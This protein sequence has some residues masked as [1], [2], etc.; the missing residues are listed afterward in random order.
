MIAGYDPAR[1][2]DLGR[3][4]HTAVTGL[5]LITTTDPAADV[6]MHAIAMMRTVLT[7]G[8]I[9]AVDSI[10]RT[11]PLVARGIAN[12][13]GA[14]LFDRLRNSWRFV[15]VGDV[16]LL[17]LLHIAF[18]DQVEG[19]G[20]PDPDDPFWTDEFPELVT[21]Y[22][23]RARRD[24]SFAQLM[25]D[26]AG[27]NPL[28]GYV[29]A[30]GSFGDAVFVG[31]TAAIVVAEPLGTIP[32]TYRDEVVETLLQQAMATPRLAVM[33]AAE[34]GVLGT[35]FA[36]NERFD[37]VY[38]LP[39]AIVVD[40]VSVAMGYPLSEPSLMA[41]GQ[42]VLGRITE[43]A[44]EPYGR[45]FPEWVAPTIATG[46]TGY[47]P[48][49]LGS[50]ETLGSDVFFKN[51]NDR[52]TVPL[53]SPDEIV[54]LFGSLLR[55]PDARLVLLAAIPILA[56]ADPR[57][58]YD[59]ED[60]ADYVNLLIQAS[61][62]EQIQDEIRAAQQRGHWNI[63]IDVVSFAIETGIEVAGVPGDGAKIAV[64]IGAKGA[65]WLVSRIEAGDL[66]LDDVRGTAYLLLTLGLA[67]RFVTDRRTAGDD[68]S[69]L[70]EAEDTVD[71]IDDLLES[72]ASTETVE[73]R[74]RDLRD[75][76]DDIGGPDALSTLDD[77]RIEPT[78]F[79]AQRDTTAD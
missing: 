35:L 69:R 21:E 68:D 46:L 73:A 1:V 20:L 28:I 9:T 66:G 25:I 33:V 3:R 43:L 57:G 65:H 47:L 19:T 14:S 4:T 24:P 38:D 55:D 64:G 74:I 13:S 5:D 15:G 10:A 61:D 70:D 77:A 17:S 41:D 78:P 11:D 67:S 50:I 45:G 72:G 36:W 56:T 48:S 51:A 18:T 7:G 62:N 23:G 40:F 26:E 54:E 53:G 63:V 79:D 8:I 52:R 44:D 59:D 42:R 39:D 31:V 16:D 71:E 60:L 12:P 6:A 30:A 75:V 37:I 27:R 34:D 2:A 58:L 29:V 22:E 49:L 32:D 76:V